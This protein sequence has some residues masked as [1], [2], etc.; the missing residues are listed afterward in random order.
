MYLYCMFIYI[1]MYIYSLIPDDDNP[2]PLE[3]ILSHTAKV[4]SRQGV[5]YCDVYG[6]ACQSTTC[7]MIMECRG[8]EQSIF[9]I[10]ENVGVCEEVLWDFTTLV[11]KSRISFSGFC[12]EKT[13]IYQTTNPQSAPFV[14]HKTFIPCFF[15]W[16]RAMQLDFRKEIDPYCLYSM[17]VIAC[18]G[19]KVGV[20]VKHQNNESLCTKPTCE[21][22]KRSK[23]RKMYRCLLPYPPQTGR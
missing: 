10:T 13:R 4:Y 19:T 6:R 17:K 2:E 16:V 9:F 1:M 20:S 5:I 23:H 15:A 7:N 11:V 12:K 21:E 3:P 14:S 22:V 8:Q 18:D